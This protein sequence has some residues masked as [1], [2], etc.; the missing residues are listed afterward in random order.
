MVAAL[1]WGPLAATSLTV[2]LF[3]GPRPNAAF[4]AMTDVFSGVTSNYQAMSIQ[5]N[6]RMSHHIQFGANYTWS[7]ALDN[8]VNGQTFVATNSLFNPFNLNSDY[9]NSIYNVPQRFVLNAVMTSPWQFNGWAKWLAN[10]WSIAPVYQVQSGLP[11]SVGVSG[12]AP[13]GT[14]NGI[15]GSGGANRILSRNS[16][17]MPSTWIADL[18]VSKSFAV[19]ERYKLELLTDFFNLANKQN[20]TG[21]NTTGYTITGTTLN[22][23]TAFDTRT[24]SNSN[25]IYSPRQIQL[26]A[27]FHF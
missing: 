6:H 16:I 25:F 24:S 17:Q 4:G 11:I 21:V 22:P 14:A 1:G 27:R 10:D 15:N 20:V 2:P 18:R 5:A 8:G 12:N 7:H 3:S 13:G 26:G 19:T 23:N 9:G